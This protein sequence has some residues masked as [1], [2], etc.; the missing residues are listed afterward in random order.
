MA[1]LFS[2]ANRH[3][4]NGGQVFVEHCHTMPTVIHSKFPGSGFVAGLKHCF[5]ALIR[6]TMANVS[7]CVSHAPRI[8]YSTIREKLESAHSNGDEHILRCAIVVQIDSAAGISN[9]PNQYSE[10]I[11]A[12]TPKIIH[13]IKRQ[14]KQNQWKNTQALRIE[15]NTLDADHPFRTGF[16]VGGLHAICGLARLCVEDASSRGNSNKA[17]TNL[18]SY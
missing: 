5:N 17:E 18:I 3:K 1:V 12:S 6:H 16:I 9:E 4:L 8:F 15:C 2:P 13:A 7:L 11:R 10:H 14:C